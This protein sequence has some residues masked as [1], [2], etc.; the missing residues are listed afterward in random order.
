MRIVRPYGSSR[1]KPVA[2]K[3]HRVLIDNTQERVEH[4]DIPE[5]AR[6]HDELVIAQWISA[7]DKIASKPD[8]RNQPTHEQRDL[9]NRI[10]NACWQQLIAGGHLLGADSEAR[11]FLA[12]LWWF[13]IHP[14]PA[15]TEQPNPDRKGSSR[16]PKVKG[17]WYERFAGEVEPGQ[18]DAVEIAAQI[19]EHLYRREYRLHPAAPTR[20]HGK[21]EARAESIG[22]NVLHTRNVPE[23]RQGR[24]E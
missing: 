1:S 7:I 2:G 24:V 4:D 5:F 22:R 20:R 12:N 19:E 8:G 9:R 6:S 18:A 23:G 13:K 11:P 17:R 21:I 16:S 10:G 3:L 15:G 14:Y